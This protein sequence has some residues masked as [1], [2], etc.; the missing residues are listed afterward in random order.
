MEKE[1][2]TWNGRLDN[3]VDSFMLRTEVGYQM[4]KEKVITFL[5][6]KMQEVNFEIPASMRNNLP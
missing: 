5:L 1:Y 2:K 3:E 6:K 4:K